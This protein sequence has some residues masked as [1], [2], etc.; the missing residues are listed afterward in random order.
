MVG[1]NRV[2]LRADVRDVVT[3]AHKLCLAYGEEVAEFGIRAVIHPPGIFQR[4]KLAVFIRPP[5]GFD[6][7]RRTLSGVGDV[8]VL[9]V[10]QGNRPAVHGQA[11]YAQKTFHGRAELVA[12]SA[13]GW[14]LNKAQ[15]LGWDS[16]AGANHGM[17]Q[18][19]AYAFGL[20]GQRAVFFHVG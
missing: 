12:K 9:V 5:F 17:V 19:Q 4:G 13:A 1:R 16:D 7:G 8:L 11:S 15:L 10:D 18:V 3:G 2:T 20:D 6:F 14:V